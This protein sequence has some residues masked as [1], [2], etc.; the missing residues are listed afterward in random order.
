MINKVPKTHFYKSLVELKITHFFDNA[1]FNY[2]SLN[3]FGSVGKWIIFVG[4]I[5]ASTCD[6]CRI[7]FFM[8]L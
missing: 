8:G 7:S 1:I 3:Y 6:H 5:C 4:L 2:F